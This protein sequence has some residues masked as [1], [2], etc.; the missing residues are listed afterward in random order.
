MQWVV[1]SN[2]ESPSE[3]N[4]G[5]IVLPGKVSLVKIQL[6]K[7]KQCSWGIF[8]IES[9]EIFLLFFLCSSQEVSQSSNLIVLY[10]CN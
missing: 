9:L 4:N 5:L 6:Y 3:S 8:F 2:V 1:I 7:V 10:H